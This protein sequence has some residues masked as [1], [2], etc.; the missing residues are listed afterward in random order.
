MIERAEEVIMLGL[1]TS[2]G[3]GVLVLFSIVAVA[4]CGSSGSSGATP[5]G[6]VAGLGGVCRDGC[7]AP[8]VCDATLGCVECTSDAACGAGRPRCVLGHCEVCAT[9]ADCPAASPACFPGDHSCHAAC[10]ADSCGKNVICNVPTGV[11]AGC[12]A[13]MDCA[14][15]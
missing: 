2:F 8:A 14:G 7:N 12:A 5:G 9:N 3:A 11:C 6:G 15:T 13:D 1:R 4:S 10:T